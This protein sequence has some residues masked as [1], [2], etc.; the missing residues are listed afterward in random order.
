M[1]YIYSLNSLSLSKLISLL[2]KA[3]KK[4]AIILDK[5][6]KY[7]GYIS[8]NQL[9]RYI[10]SGANENDTVSIFNLKKNFLRVNELSDRTVLEKRVIEFAADFGEPVVIINDNKEV[11]KVI[12]FNELNVNYFSN[13]NSLKSGTQK[14]V[15]VIGG[16]GY[17]GSVLTKK[18]LLRGYSVRIFDLF[19][20]GKSHLSKFKDENIEI[21]QGDIRNIEAISNALAD[22]DS[23]ILLAAVVGDPASIARPHQTIQT[24]F[25]ATQAI[26]SACK[27]E[28]I[29]RFIY[30]STCSVYGHSDDLLD[31]SSP[32]NPVSLY[33][34]T[35]IAS[36]DTIKNLVNG[37]FAPTILRVSTLY[38]YSPRMRF[39]LVVNTMTLK[40]FLDNE[41]LVFGGEQ[42]RPILDINDAADSY[43]KVLEADINLIKGK[44]YNVGTELQNY[45]IK[46]L[47]EIVSNTLNEININT[48]RSDVDRRNYKV[49][50]E[51]IQKELSFIPKVKLEES[52]RDI[53]FKL[54]NNTIKNPKNKKYYNHF[55]DS[56]EEI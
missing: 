52:I 50:F 16:G 13:I 12:T 34:R 32:M 53:F 20:Y 28:Q 48:I 24:N 29:N 41:I 7:K 14:K 27:F 25:L 43:I 31:E 35:K 30:A 54:K 36:E 15:L 8:I 3:N 33:A 1:N 22:I 21:I 37:N 56:S 4:Y 47:A 44:I 42:W 51:K 45:K 55:F 10:V 9:R 18:L 2:D 38:G 19:I 6:D 17:L 5:K 23:V 49:S 40:A 26:V 46:E 11:E 39:D